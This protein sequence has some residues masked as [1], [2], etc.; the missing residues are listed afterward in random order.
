MSISSI[1][2][3]V[4][5][6]EGDNKEAPTVKREVETGDDAEVPE[7]VVVKVARVV[8]PI[9]NGHQADSRLHCRVVNYYISR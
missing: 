2:T 5:L 8:V 9:I 1:T 4:D 3:P 6:S 7:E